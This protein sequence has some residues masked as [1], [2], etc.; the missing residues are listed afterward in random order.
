MFKKC[1][2]YKEDTYLFCNLSEKYIKETALL[3]NSEWPRSLSQ[4]DSNLRSLSKTTNE[5]NLPVSLILILKQE[6]SN[7]MDKVIGHLSIVPIFANQSGVSEQTNYLAFIQSVIIDKDWRGRGLGKKMML[8]SEQ[9]FIEY[10][11]QQRVR[12][13]QDDELLNKNSSKITN[14]DYLF[15][16]TKD[17]QA[18]YESLGYISIEPILCYTVK[19]DSRCSQI[20][21]NLFKNMTV[22]NSNNNSNNVLET[23]KAVPK[24]TTGSE[25]GFLASLPPNSPPPPPPPPLPLRIS[26][27]TNDVKC[28]PNQTYWYKKCI[29]CG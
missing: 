21:K 8:L 20:M 28:L 17:Q 18:F 1:F 4:R 19:D 22:S 11:K 2:D 27:D 14:F 24:N 9:Y 15:L 13:T 3:L 10:G 23:S 6:K 5:F 12:E 26:N 7:P 25:S 16:T 29:I